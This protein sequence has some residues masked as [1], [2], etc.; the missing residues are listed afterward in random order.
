MAVRAARGEDWTKPL[1]P[2][3]PG[4]YERYRQAK[5]QREER[6]AVAAANR[7]RDAARAAAE[8]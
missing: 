2:A 8:Q 6:G 1:R 5:Q 3:D 7:L 4:E